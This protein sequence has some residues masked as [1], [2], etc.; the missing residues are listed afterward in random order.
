MPNATVRANARTL[1]EETERLSEAS[2]RMQAF[3]RA[4][5][6]WLTACAQLEDLNTQDE[7]AVD[8]MFLE[9]RTALRELFLVPASECEA[10]WA[11]LAAFEVDLVRE[12]IAG[13]AKDSILMLG[14][15]SIKADLMNL[16]IG[17]DALSPPACRTRGQGGQ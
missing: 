8:G 2:A 15:G 9:E 6:R 5:A 4:Y 17:G 16:G 3:G 10:V 11:K 12:R 13:E 14:L 1:P 7:D